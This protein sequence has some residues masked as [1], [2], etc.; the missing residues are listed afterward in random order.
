MPVLS[1]AWT[2]LMTVFPADLLITGNVLIAKQPVFWTGGRR[3]FPIRHHSGVSVPI[4][5]P[6]IT[7]WKK[8]TNEGRGTAKAVSVSGLLHVRNHRNCFRHGGK[9]VV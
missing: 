6:T 1:L 7:V 4:S 8:L 2:S 5:E 9:Y 3:P